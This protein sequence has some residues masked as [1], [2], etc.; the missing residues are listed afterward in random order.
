MESYQIGDRVTVEF[1][2]GV[3]QIVER[4]WPDHITEEVEEEEDDRLFGTIV[5][6]H[7]P[8]TEELFDRFI[9]E[10]IGRLNDMFKKGIPR[11]LIENCEKDRERY[12]A[13]SL[14]CLHTIC[15]E[16]FGD[17][18]RRPWFCPQHGRL[19]G[20]DHCHLVAI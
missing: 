2:E 7:G 18:L 20:Y 9:R 13:R 11:V 6:R 1:K 19:S 14:Y 5:C 15:P 16:E 17:D 3:W 8:V 12:V 10:E 4:G